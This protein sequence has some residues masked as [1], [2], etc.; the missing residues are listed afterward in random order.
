MRPFTTY[1][2]FVAKLGS[3]GSLLWN[4]FLGGSERDRGY[5]IDV[6]S[7]GR[8]LVTGYSESSWGVPIRAYT[9][10]TDQWTQADAFVARLD[11][12]GVLLWNTFLGGNRLDR[13]Y[14]AHVSQEGNLYVAGT[15]DV[16]WDVS[17][18]ETYESALLARLDL[19]GN[20]V[21]HHFF[22]G[23]YDDFAYGLASDND[24]N[25]VVSGY[26]DNT[27]G[28]P[29]LPSAGDT[30]VFIAKFSPIASSSWLP[31]SAIQK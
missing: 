22:G 7:S 19:D 27:W 14:A 15:S 3:N 29:I 28:S 8:I 23:P 26:S 13:G 21:W 20:L 2:A 6:D 9:E 12:D 18:P 10:G 30:S 17:T 5:G 24:G 11:S 31:W 25:V 16:S 4:T 1:D